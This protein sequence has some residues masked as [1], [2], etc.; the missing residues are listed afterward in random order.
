MFDI[1]HPDKSSWIPGHCEIPFST[2]LI[3]ENGNIFLCV[4]QAY[5]PKILCNILDIETCEEFWQLYYNNE[6]KNSILDKSHRFCKSNCSAIQTAYHKLP[7][8]NFVSYEELVKIK[9]HTLQLC[10]DNSCNLRCPTCRTE[11]ILHHNNF[12]YQSRLQKILN[13]IDMIFFKTQSIYKVHLLS[14]GEFLASKTILNWM[15]EKSKQNIRFILQTNGNLIYNYRDKCSEIFKKTE[16]LFISI[17]AATPEVYNKVRVGGNWNNLITS[18]DWLKV[19]CPKLN[20]FFNYTISSL[21]YVDTKNFIKFSDKYKPKKIYFSRVENWF[22]NPKIFEPLD[23]W[24]NDHPENGD[25][26]ELLRDTNFMQP[27]IITNFLDYITIV[28]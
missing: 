17:D 8:T 1:N 27:N 9:P 26:I 21:N 6:I 7:T 15:F 2:I 19:N 16:S 22:D 3:D 24:N 4:C 25:F 5:L 20:L 14:G 18:L 23:I 13:K 11:M 28:S 10:I 12:D